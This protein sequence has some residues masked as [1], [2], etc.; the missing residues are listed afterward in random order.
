MKKNDDV[1]LPKQTSEPIV[2]VDNGS[3]KTIPKD[4]GVIKLADIFFI[5]STLGLGFALFTLFSFIGIA[6]YYLLLIV[7]LLVT[8]FTLIVKI[9]PWFQKGEII[10]N[11]I[12]SISPYQPYVII[13]S[14]A[15][16]L[17]ALLIYIFK[18]NYSGKTGRIVKTSIILFVEIIIA[19]FIYYIVI[20]K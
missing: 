9:K 11:I 10:L 3:K 1:E 15:F 19:I 6:L 17:S 7:L 12:E 13:T 14:I 18:K 2:T 16:S 5:L 4:A 8:L 20:G